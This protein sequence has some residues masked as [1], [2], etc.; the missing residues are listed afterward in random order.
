MNPTSIDEDAGSISGF[1]QWVKDSVLPMSCGVRCRCSLDAALLWLWQRPAAAAAPIR[2]LA[3]ELPDA[4][5]AALKR[6][7]TKIHKGQDRI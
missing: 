4:S 6:K 2:P 3:W 5:D 7:K 1:A